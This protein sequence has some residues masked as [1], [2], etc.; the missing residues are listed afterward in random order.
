M[1]RFIYRGCKLV[2]SLFAVV[3]VAGAPACDDGAGSDDGGDDQVCVGGKC[4]D[5]DV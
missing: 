2:V 3:V 4:D 1:T 5:V